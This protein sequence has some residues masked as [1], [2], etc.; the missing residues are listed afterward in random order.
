MTGLVPPTPA[1]LRSYR[2]SLYVAGGVSVR[3][4]RRP[5]AMPARWA[6][7]DLVLLSACN[8]SGRR[9]PDGWNRRMM[10]GLRGALRDLDHAEGEGRYRRWSEPLLLVA[11]APARGIAMA[12]RFRQNAVILLHDRRPAKL[13]LLA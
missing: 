1:V 11:V 6:G 10:H 3:V 4:D 2:R 9:R 12:R 8:P 7:R 13:V 5:E